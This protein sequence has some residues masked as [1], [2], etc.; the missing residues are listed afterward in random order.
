MMIIDYCLAIWSKDTS[1]MTF[2]FSNPISM[3]ASIAR[4]VIFCTLFLTVSDIFSQSVFIKTA[5]F[6]NVESGNLISDQFIEV[7][8]ELIKATGPNGN[9]PNG[10]EIIDLSGSIIMP[11]M[12]EAHTHLALSTQE[13]RDFNRF[14]ITNILES[15]PYRAIQGVTNARSL[16]E[17]GFTSIRDLGNNGYYADLD[18]KRAIREGWIPGPDM[19][20]VG[21]IIAPFG[22]QFQL[23]QENPE[24]VATDYEVAD[25]KD[26]MMKAIRKNLH[27]G[28]DLIKIVVDDYD[29]IYSKE[30]V[31]FAA[32]EVHRAG[33]KIAAH[34]ST[35]QGAKNAIAAGVNSLEHAWELDQD[36]LLSMKEKGIFLVGTDF[37]ESYSGYFTGYDE[38]LAKAAYQKRID[39]LERSYQ[40]GV[41]IAFGADVT[42]HVQGSS[43]GSQT[44]AFISSFKD[45]GIGS[46]DLIRILTINGASLMG[47]EAQKGSVS[48]GKHADLIAMR[49]NPLTNPEALKQISFVM[50]RGKIYKKDGKFVWSTPTTIHVVE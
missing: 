38:S 48:V 8:G 24:L 4:A 13:G 17:H 16:L 3:K 42:D 35:N 26:E 28:A 41:K 15:T 32:D 31:Q 12:I 36:D 1:M 7:E 23:P 5:G 39:R 44:I 30:M 49:E 33:R 6:V 34:V 40:A 46:A 25:S 43:K 45:A 11:G 22:G 2:R 21:R 14:F 29:Y 9:I 20:A 18:L 50:K 27:F 37:P 19:Q 10:A 47:W